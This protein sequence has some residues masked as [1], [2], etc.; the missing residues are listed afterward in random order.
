MTFPRSGN[1]FLRKYLET[2]TGSPTGSEMDAN[3]TM[4]LQ[5]SGLIG[6]QVVDDSCWIIKTHHPGRVMALNFSANKIIVCVRNPFD[7]FRSLHNFNGTM[8]HS[9]ALDIDLPVKHPEYFWGLCKVL[10][11]SYV[12]FQ[13]EIIKLAKEQTV[14]LYFFKFEELIKT[15]KES[16]ENVFKFLYDVEDI[17]GTVIEKRIQDVLEMGA[18][19][20]QAYKLKPTDQK[21]KKGVE[22][23][24]AE[25]QEIILT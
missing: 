5:M 2:I 21:Y 16:L 13:D 10:L 25:Q 19:A 22:M 12:A 8:T 18:S 1:T 14:P 4:P 9:H 6:E 17:T 11:K 20:N 3:V 23:F 24:S 7:V 15:P